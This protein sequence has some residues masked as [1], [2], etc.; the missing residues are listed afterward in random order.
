MLPALLSP[1]VSTMI[2][3]DSRVRLA[4]PVERH[5]DAV[6]DRGA[7]PVDDPEVQLGQ[8]AQER[9]VVERER[10]LRV[11]L[12]PEDHQ[13]DAIGRAPAHEV[14]DHRLGGVEAVGHAGRSPPSSPTRRARSRCRCPRARG[15]RRRAWSAGA[16]APRRPAPPPRGAAPSADRAGAPPGRGRCAPSSRGARVGEERRAAPGAARA[17]PPTA[18]A[19]PP[20][21]SAPAR[22]GAR[23]GTP[24]RCAAARRRRRRA[25]RTPPRSAP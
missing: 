14:L 10:D 16:P 13:A 12:A 24:R 4:Q 7:V 23:S 11:G 19:R 1:S 20:T 18:P 25:A 22:P 6:A 15:R 3:F 8:H 9:A 17:G 21:G 5:A 2:T